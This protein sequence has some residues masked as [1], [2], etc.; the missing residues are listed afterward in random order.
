MKT[1][2]EDWEDYKNLVL[3]PNTSIGQ[4]YNAQIAF[5]AGVFTV[6][7]KLRELNLENEEESIKILT[8]IE[9]ECIEFIMSL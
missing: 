7:K 1:L 6:I 5:Y 4:Y 3:S 8:S 9:S 2:K